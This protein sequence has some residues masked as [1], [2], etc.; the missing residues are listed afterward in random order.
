MK[1]TGIVFSLMLLAGILL[2]A[3]QALALAPQPLTVALIFD[4]GGRGDGGFNDAAQRGLE[5]AVSEMGVRAVYI[6]HRRN[7]EL[8]HAVDEAAASD[9]QV[10][11]GVGF[12]FSEKLRRLAL[13]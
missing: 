10:I 3:G 8:A 1:K 11:I 5:K 6:E 9:A 13:Q 2:A 12:A 4:I 7:L